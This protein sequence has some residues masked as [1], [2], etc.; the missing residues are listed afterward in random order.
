MSISGLLYSDSAAIRENI[1][2]TLLFSL[3][4][5]IAPRTYHQRLRT[6]APIFDSLFVAS[7][8]PVRRRTGQ[9]GR[10]A[11]E[12]SEVATER[13]INHVCLQWLSGCDR[14]RVLCACV[15]DRSWKIIMRAPVRRSSATCAMHS[16]ACTR[17]IVSERG[18][19][20]EEVIVNRN[21]SSLV[22]HRR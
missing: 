17:I 20:T 10:T 2:R 22:T 14:Q 16:S 9:S 4:S 13:E 19:Q 1:H 12:A 21:V 6:T 18:L 15:S 5:L 3:S 8:E 11:V 7:A